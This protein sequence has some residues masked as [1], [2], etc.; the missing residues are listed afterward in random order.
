[1]KDDKRKSADSNKAIELDPTSAFAYGSRGIDKV[2]IGNYKGA[3]TDFSKAI[4]LD[5]KNADRYKQLIKAVKE[6][7]DNL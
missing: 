4:E 5:P 3:I 7:P 1:M 2:E 6:Q